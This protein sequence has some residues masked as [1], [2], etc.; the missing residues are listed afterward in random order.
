MER[1]GSVLPAIPCDMQWRGHVVGDDGSLWV[2][3]Q[4]AALYTAVTAGRYRVT[5]RVNRLGMRHVFCRDET[6]A[7][8]YV[9]AWARKWE[10]HLRAEYPPST[11]S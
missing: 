7:T 4:L 5:L 1:V 9:G 10:A 8:R 3:G 2:N 11:D 6:E